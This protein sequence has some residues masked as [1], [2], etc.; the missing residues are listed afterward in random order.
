VASAAY[1]KPA[2]AAFASADDFKQL[3][4]LAQY[5]RLLLGPLAPHFPPD[6]LPGAYERPPASASKKN[7]IRIRSKGCSEASG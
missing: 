4:T 5:L 3:R 6:R 7:T 1:C 2:L